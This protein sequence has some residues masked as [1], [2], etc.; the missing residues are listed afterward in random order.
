M[1]TASAAWIQQIHTHT[2]DI[3]MSIMMPILWY[4]YMDRNEMSA[5]YLFCT[6]HGKMAVSHASVTNSYQTARQQSVPK[7]IFYVCCG[8]AAGQDTYQGVQEGVLEGTIL[9]TSSKCPKYSHECSFVLTCGS[10]ECVVHGQD[11]RHTTLLEVS[12]VCIWRRACGG[13]EDSLR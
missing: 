2:Y 12:L 4:T 13:C 6:F 3:K 1:V 11:A 7:S 10:V 9:V 8:P 5:N